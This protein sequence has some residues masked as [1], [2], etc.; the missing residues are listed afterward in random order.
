[1]DS[2]GNLFR[3]PDRASSAIQKFSSGKT[4]LASFAAFI[5]LAALIYGQPFGLARLEEIT[6]GAGILDM[7]FTYTPQQAYAML[8]ALGDAGREFYL[9][10]ILPLDLIVPLAY[11]VFYA[12]TISWFL[13]RW[14][15]AESPWMR[16][17]VVPLV[18]GIADYCE[19]IGVI[20]MLLFYPTE[21]YGVAAVTGVISTV[22]FL[23]VVASILLV[24][25]A[26]AGWAVS[27]LRER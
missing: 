9:T 19:D 12:V 17:N 26:L 21:L 1:M 15:P 3:I 22:K 13:S 11:A 4:V 24:L 27:V 2:S 23:L 7:E 8:G 6:G 10:S 5:V 14:L 25:G 16:L 18:A 20:T